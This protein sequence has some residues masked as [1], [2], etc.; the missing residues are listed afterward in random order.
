VIVTCERCATQFQLDDERV[1]EDGVRVRCSRCKHAFFIE[2]PARNEAEKIH[3]IASR[4]VEDAPEVTKDLDDVRDPLPSD[5]ALD[6]EDWQFADDAPFD[7]EEYTDPNGLSAADVVADLL[8]GAEDGGSAAEA[9]D[10]FD[11]SGLVG[12]AS[13]GDDLGE[14]EGMSLSLEDD[15][16]PFSAPSSRDE[17][18]SDVEIGDTDGDL[19]LSLVEDQVS[20]AAENALDHGLVDIGGEDAGGSGLEL[21]GPARATD[22]SG[23]LADLR[24][25]LEEEVPAVAAPMDAGPPVQQREV[26]TQPTRRVAAPPDQ[27]ELSGLEDCGLA[28][29]AESPTVATGLTLPTRTVARVPTDL[30]EEP[31]A[32]AQWLARVGSIVG[33]TCVI[34]LFAVGLHSGVALQAA[35]PALAPEAVHVGGFDVSEVNSHWIDNLHVGPTL[36]VSGTLRNTAASAST[37]LG[38]ALLGADGQPIAETLVAV[39]P[40]LGEATLRGA[41]PDT[42]A[43]AQRELGADGWPWQSGQ[44]RRFHAVAHALPETATWV[45]F[46]AVGGAMSAPVDAAGTPTQTSDTQDAAVASGVAGA[47]ESAESGAPTAGPST[48][49]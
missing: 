38:V 22:A 14:E 40:A 42:F 24:D 44:E 48:P 28:E 15:D 31:S 43:E 34:G 11:V 41:H 1:P 35:P 10:D 19:S 33:W 2:R 49:R 25:E 39:G 9:S 23:L 37:G 36:V 8:G 26:V 46:E 20:E 27:D 12:E 16:E 6:E 21:D 4:A 5:D 45:R 17:S 47:G 3:R 13:D 32:R 18:G 30:E 7:S 29:E